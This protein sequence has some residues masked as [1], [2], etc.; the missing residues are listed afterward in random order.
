MIKDVKGRDLFKVKMRAKSYALNLFEE[1][2]QLF[3]AQSVELNHDIKTWH[4]H[5]VE[6]LYMHKYAPPKGVSSMGTSKM[7][8]YC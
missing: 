7:A 1:S 5:R 6:I 4:F 2:K 8:K 3:Q